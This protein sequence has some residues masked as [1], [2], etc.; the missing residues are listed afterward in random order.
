MTFDPWPSKSVNLQKSVFEFLFLFA[1]FMFTR[2]DGL[3]TLE[4]LVAAAKK[5]E[6]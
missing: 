5:K 3:T 2:T 1:I 6:N 4:T